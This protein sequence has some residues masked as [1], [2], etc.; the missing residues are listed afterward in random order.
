MSIPILLD[1][2][3]Y[4]KVMH[5]EEQRLRDTVERHATAAR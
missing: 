4:M 5:A 1:T 2:F 3:A